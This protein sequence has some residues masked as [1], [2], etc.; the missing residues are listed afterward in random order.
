MQVDPPT[1]TIAQLKA[2]RV[3]ARRMLSAPVSLAL[4]GKTTT[5]LTPK[6]LAPMLQLPRE[7]DAAPALGGAAANA[8]FARL[9]HQVGRP[10]HGAT[11]AVSGDQVHVVPAVDGL[12]LDVAAFGRAV[13]TAALRADNRVARLVVQRTAHGTDDRGGPGDGD[14]R[15]RSARTRRSTAGSRT[16]STTC[17]SSPTWSTTS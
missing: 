4:D 10:A 6:Q 15:L 3:E 5:T 12:A 16:G 17:S 8:Y 1:L 7:P 9:D 13:L 11:F 2:A 14:H